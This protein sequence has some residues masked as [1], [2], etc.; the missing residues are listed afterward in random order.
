MIDRANPRLRAAIAFCAA[1][2]LA[3]CSGRGAAQ[4]GGSGTAATDGGAQAQADA[5]GD[6]GGDGADAGSNWP[7]VRD[8]PGGTL[9]WTVVYKGTGTTKTPEMEEV[10][11]LHR[12]LEG[13]A[14]MSGA[15]GNAGD[16]PHPKPL[17]DINKAMEAC[18][19]DMACQ[20]KAA[21]QA[22]AAMQKDPDAFERSMRGAM[23][24]AQRDTLWAADDCDITGEADDKATWSGMTPGGFNTG[25][26]VRTGRQAVEGCGE[27]DP[28]RL[29]A[30]DNT[31]TYKL[32]IPQARIRVPASFDGKREESLGRFVMFP[33]LAVEGVRYSRLD[34]PLKGSASLRTGSGIGLYSEGW[35]MP[36]VEEV[37]WT[38]TP[39]AH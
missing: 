10:V 34:R 15:M 5:G 20:R 33:A 4:T 28:P 29:V 2:L 14:H 16:T 39:D 7:E 25:H 31:H 23:T 19:D 37:S 27:G 26:G 3:A 38:F 30:D 9:A 13:T 21:M 1:M 11:V 24:E 8:V 35:S 6:G 12:K 32:T 36:L 18:G 22:M 17:E